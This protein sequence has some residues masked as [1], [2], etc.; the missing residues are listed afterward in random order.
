MHEI[1]ADG[2]LIQ[3][4]ANR[5]RALLALD[6]GERIAAIAHWLGWSRM[7]L[8]PLWQRYPEWGGAAVCDAER[9]GRPSIFPP[10]ERVRIACVACPAPAAYGRHLARWD[11]RS[12]PHM[13]VERA[14]VG[15]IHDTTVARILAVASLQ[16]H[17][18]RYW[19]TAP[20]DERFTTQAAKMLWRYE[21]VEWLDDRGEVVRCRD[22]TPQMPV[23]VRR[24]PTQ[25]RPCGQI[26]RREFESKRDGT[27]T[28]LVA[29]NVDDGTRW[30]CCLEAI[31]RLAR[32]S[33]VPGGCT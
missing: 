28:F 13:V 5:A 1:L 21:R 22:E 7:G 2:Q 16:P 4:V 26:A 17:R 11:C 19:K 31:G 15:S 29:F 33:P 12:L 18:H 8:W 3:R 32:R 20:M 14:V 23:L 10:L 6:R 9:C 30:G 27:V 25:P 24:I